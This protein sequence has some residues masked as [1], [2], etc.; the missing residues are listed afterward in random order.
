MT[1]QPSHQPT[2]RPSK[3][4]SRQPTSRPSSRPLARPS[5]QPTRQPT[6]QPTRRPLSGPSSQPT[7]QPTQQPTCT[8]L[9]SIS[10][11]HYNL[12]MPNH[13]R[14]YFLDIMIIIS[15]TSPSP[16]TKTINSPYH[17]VSNTF[18]HPP[19]F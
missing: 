5:T 18:H 11:P 1:G 17:Y 9:P 4:P 2:R 6:Q 3:R 7:K 12:K 19:F 13:Y 8:K 14:K 10:Y 15:Y 16:K